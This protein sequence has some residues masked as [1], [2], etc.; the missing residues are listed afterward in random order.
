MREDVAGVGRV[1]GESCAA[2]KAAIDWS[3]L[4]FLLFSLR[5]ESAYSRTCEIS[6]LEVFPESDFIIFFQNIE[7]HEDE[8]VFR[9]YNVYLAKVCSW[10][11]L[12]CPPRTNYIFSPENKGKFVAPSLPGRHRDSASWLLRGRLSIV[13]AENF[14]SAS[15][16]YYSHYFACFSMFPFCSIKQNFNSSWL[17]V[18]FGPP[19]GRQITC[20]CDCVCSFLSNL[21]LRPKFPVYLRL[22]QFFRF[23]FCI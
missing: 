5:V 8:V 13:W 4:F 1:S 3:S 2:W 18:N 6:S 17:I 10:N 21:K 20:P 12:F 16:C 22:N 11:S 9:N 14:N 7:F 15:Q 23:G 19:R